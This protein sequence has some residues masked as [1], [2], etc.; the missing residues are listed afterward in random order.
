MNEQL[1]GAVERYGS[2]ALFG[3]IAIASVGIPLPVTLLLIVTGSIAAQGAI[4]I[5]QAI[6]IATLGSVAGDQAGYALG[7]WGGPA[8]ITRFSRFLGGAE[9]MKQIDARMQRWGDASVFLSRWLITALGPWVN[10]ASGAAKYS[11]LRFTLWDLLGEA[12]DAILYVWLGFAFSDRVQEVGAIIGD[13]GKALVGVVAA[14][15][16][17]AKLFRRSPTTAA[18]AR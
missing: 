7:R 9:R 11:W 3:V 6:A 15:A 17:G 14:V 2:P 1:L 4:N 18:A 10:L 5:W 13:A 8:L 16:I 12:V